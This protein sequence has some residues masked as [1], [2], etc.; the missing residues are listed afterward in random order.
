MSLSKFSENYKINVIG[1]TKLKLWTFTNALFNLYVPGLSRSP[2]KSSV[3]LGGCFVGGG[4]VGVANKSGSSS[5]VLVKREWLSV[6][7]DLSGFTLSL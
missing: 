5:S 7:R 6:V 2:N 1:P 3:S 4:L